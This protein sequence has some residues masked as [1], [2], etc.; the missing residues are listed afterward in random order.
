MATSNSPIFSQ[1]VNIGTARIFPADLSD[2]KTILVAG[3]NGTLID[4]IHV[5]TDESSSRD[6]QFWTTTQDDFPAA[7]ILTSTGVNVSNNDTVTI[8][9]KLYT[10]QTTLTNTVDGNVKIGTTAALSLSNLSYAINNQGGVVGT[11]YATATTAHPTVR[12]TSFTNTTIKV[13]ALATG[14]SGNSIA[15]TESATTLS[16]SS[17]TL[18]GGSSSVYV[19]NL[20]ATITIP[21]NSGFTNAVGLVSVLDQVRF[22]ASSA[23]T[24]FQVL[25]PNGN[26]LLR[27]KGNEILKV[28]SLSTITAAR[29]IYIRAS[30]ADL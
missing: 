10:F 5:S 4:F 15:T 7:G 26:K 8:A 27:L 29:S 25:D 3:P 22:G 23:P 2:L 1:G 30:G 6:L 20:L 9:G 24:G 16:W 28:K 11:D 19:D 18:A 21:A 17:A 12:A 14:T 13:T